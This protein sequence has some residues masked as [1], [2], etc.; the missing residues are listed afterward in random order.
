MKIALILCIA[1]VSNYIAQAQLVPQ[2]N[3]GFESQI[4]GFVENKGQIRDQH[5]RT[6]DDVCFLYSAGLFNLQLQKNGFSY[7]VFELIPDKYRLNESGEQ[8]MVT[9]RQF[10]RMED[11]KQLRSQR[12]DVKVVGAAASVQIVGKDTTGA[13]L[14]YYTT[15]TPEK[16]IT[17]V[18]SFQQVVYKNIY[19]GIDLI[20]SVPE[21]EQGTALNYE[22]IIHPGAD[23]QKIKLQYS[24]SVPTVGLLNGGYSFRTAAGIISESNVI[25][26][27][28]EEHLIV[29]ASYKFKG[30]T[31]SYTINPDKQETIV[32]DPNIIWS[33]YFGGNNDEENVWGQ[34]TT[35]SKKRVIITGATTSTQFIASNGAHQTTYGG[36]PY[37]AYVAMFKANGKLDWATYYGSDKSDK[38]IQVTTTSTDDIYLAGWTSSSTGIATANVHQAIF[39]GV[40]DVFIAKFDDSG[41]RQWCTYLGGSIVD[42]VFGITCDLH[43]NL[44]FSGYTLSNNQ[45]S[46]TGSY[47]EIKSGNEGEAFIG[48]MNPEGGIEWCSY[49]GALGNDRGHGIVLGNHGDL[50][51]QGTTTSNSGLSTTGVHQSDYGGGINDAFLAKWDTS[52]NFFWCTYFG[53]E[54]DE[55]GREIVTDDDGNVYAV[56]MT[57]SKLNIASEDAF[58]TAWYEGYIGNLRLYDGYI[59]KFESDGSLDW[60]TYYGGDSEDQLWTIAI[61]RKHD[62]LYVG[63]RTLS[64]VNISTPE[65]FMPDYTGAVDGFVGKFTTEG[66]RNWGTYIGD[67]GAQDLHSLALDG[68][69]FLLLYL[70][71]DQNFSVTPGAYQTASN[72]GLE[73]VVVKFSVD[74]ACDD[75]YEPNNSFETAVKLT[76]YTDSLLY[77]YTGSIE[78]E[79][80][81]DWFIIKTTSITNLMIEL[82]EL[83]ADYDLKLYKANGD[84]LFTSANPGTSAETII[85]NNAPKSGYRLEIAHGEE[86]YDP[87]A[88]YKLKTITSAIPWLAKEYDKISNAYPDQ[89]QAYFYPNPC[90]DL[91]KIKVVSQ[92]PGKMTLTLY[93]VLD[94]AVFVRHFDSKST[95]EV[96]TVST[97]ELAGGMYLM[98]VEQSGCRISEMIVVQK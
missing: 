87:D 43:G 41:I 29:D 13:M 40:E 59:A 67:S 1:F 2:R 54:D 95:I 12:I 21:K 57:S 38:G 77:G 90:N 68:K 23:Y 64:T 78:D 88:C 79:E 34:I 94:Q 42:E 63:G 28:E 74:K 15:N 65:S 70:R 55:R 52:G 35:D 8:R 27:T 24:G 9:G 97:K 26:F 71:S 85:Y 10:D 17:G 91:L 7:E 89:L 46:T 14:N 53:G 11:Y 32:I 39:G 33:S 30:N 80:D 86:A 81:E 69:G 19:D 18:Q 45:I 82:T 25:A 75:T 56:G 37:D 48:K 93:N 5:D 50:F 51:L 36:D 96:M 4:N 66:E 31:V 44:F 16:G 61:D 22:W 3:Y 98:E 49:F 60:S 72:G 92:A 6:N 73:T 58:Q 47:Q 20:F 83:V 76:P 84:L 62:V